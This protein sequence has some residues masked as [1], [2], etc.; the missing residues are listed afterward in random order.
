[1]RGVDHGVGVVARGCGTGGWTDTPPVTYEHGGAVVN[2]AIL[3]DGKRPIGAKVR[4]IPENHLVLVMGEQRIVVDNVDTLRTFTQPQS[5]G[6]LLKAVRMGYARPLHACSMG[7]NVLCQRDR[8]LYRQKLH[9]QPCRGID[10]E[11]CCAIVTI[12]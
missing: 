12:T 3:I 8:V 2:A 4:R 10:M 11:Q 6:A 7:Y 9:V 5:P 1:M